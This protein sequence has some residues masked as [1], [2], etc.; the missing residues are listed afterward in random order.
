MFI[1]TLALMLMLSCSWYQGAAFAEGAAIQFKWNGKPQA[2]LFPKTY[3]EEEGVLT[4]R[5]SNE[6]SAPAYGTVSMKQFRPQKVWELKTTVSS[7]GG[8]AGWTGQPA[9]VK[10]RPEVLKTMNVKPKFKTKKNFTEVIYASLGGNVYFLDLE[11]GE[12]TR[13]PIRVGNP[14]K[15]S[16]SV[17]ARGYPLLYVGE[18]IPENGTIGFKLYS[19]ID[20]KKL[21]AVKGVDSFAHRKWG[22][23]DGSA[24]FNRKEDSLMVGGEN[25][26]IYNIKLNTVF[27]PAK[28]SLSIRPVIGK[29]RYLIAGNSYQGIENSIAS[30]GQF[31]YFAD[32]GGSLQGMDL[33]THTPIWSLPPTDDTDATIAVEAVNG[34][35]FLYTGTEVDKQG[36]KGVSLIRKI[37]GRTGKV[38]WQRRYPCF[39]LLG[40]HPV[41]GGL[42]ATPVIGKREIGNRVIFT[43]ARYGTFNGGLMVALDKAT[44]KEI[45]KL[46]MQA[47]AWSSPVDVYDE[48][49]RAY[50]VQAD[51]RG[52]LFVIDAA[53]GKVKGKVNAGSNIE[54]SP[55]IFNNMVVVATRGGKMLGFKLQ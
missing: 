37:D 34:N 27:N 30:F 20:Q 48:K 2:Q 3:T 53:N 1:K 24:L 6:R 19:L 55:A 22:A 42:L 47:Y 12:Q 31:A 15:G 10:W 17:D 25:G 36:S 16:V 43:L 14:I 33:Q 44:G 18:G 39:T 41:N 5:G 32:N 29:Y 38:I 11:T 7:W 35:P 51:S 21:L 9:I 49:G 54:A 23:F 46:P 26:L 40:D 52:T 28:K 50:I 13:S 45:W 4:F 8:G